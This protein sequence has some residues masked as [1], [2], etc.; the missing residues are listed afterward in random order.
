MSA[1]SP[2][3]L[4][5]AGPVVAADPLHPGIARFRRALWASRLHFLVLGM[6]GGAW[7]VHI[8]SVKA[9]YGLGEA[10]L[11]LVLFAAASG[12]V[13]SLLFAGR[14]IGRLGLRPALVLSAALMAAML[15][16]TLH[17]P[18]LPWLLP[19]MVA[20]GAA[21]SLYDVAINTEGTALES[22]G[23]R[24]V[25]GG[26]HGMFSLGGMAGAA[27]AAVLLRAE[28]GA[29]LQLGAV[30]VAVALL[31]ALAA[32]QML[33]A[34]PQEDGEQAHFAWP[35]GLLLV[36]G[37]LIFAGMT[38]EGVMYDWCVLYLK[39]ELGM[40]QAQA[41]MGFAAFS[42]AMALARFGGDALRQRF[43]ERRLVVVGASL[44]A[45]A[46]AALLLVGHPLLALVGYVLVGAG[47]ALVVPILY[48]AA[49]KV[50]G[51]SRPAAIASVSSIG[52]AGFL[53]GPPLIGSV[54]QVWS[55]TAAMSLV[56]V[57]AAVLALG[58]RRIP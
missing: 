56:A 53:I 16:L 35:H 58:A 12:A 13:L 25:M 7:G 6:M 32:R 34:H 46:M 21:M 55:L 4:P 2:L 43:A 11:S 24:A 52:Y 31:A 39:Q 17:W 26:L 48:N 28:V 51:V 29:A 33:E 19:T 23:G 40:A 44:A 1:V 8:P 50:P 10:A 36:I 20:F 54:A 5:A 30:A 15:A 42:A 3:D 14:L 41:G 27:L 47:L 9:R 45:V 38:A 49:T 57:A 22:L 37:L 18:G